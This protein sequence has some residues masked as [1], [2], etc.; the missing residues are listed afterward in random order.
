MTDSAERTGRE[1]AAV[2]SAENG[3]AIQ[4][5]AQILCAAVQVV[6]RDGSDR[7]R[8]KD[9]ADRAGVSL[10]LVQH[11][12][13]NRQDLMA[14]TFQVMMSV[15]LDAWHQLA[16]S[17]PDPLVGLFTGLRLHVV[18]TVTFADR[19]GFWMELWSAARR[20]PTLSEIAHD[21]YARWTE[22]FRKTVEALDSDGRVQA[23]D[24]YDDTAMV[25]MALVDGLAVRSLVDPG[26]LDAEQMYEHL[27]NVV[28]ALLAIDPSAAD[29]ASAR[30]REVVCAGEF[31]ESLTPDLI[32]RILSE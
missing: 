22:P 21:V 10:G 27:V 13:R 9:I 23:H 5:R 24:R 25:L 32:A 12:F 30:A 31:T 1:T 17:Q 20:D 26:A 7:A 15:S 3:S 8:L 16:A 19:W 14:Q 29:A 2:R 11:Y 6:A 28:R 18:G 4:R